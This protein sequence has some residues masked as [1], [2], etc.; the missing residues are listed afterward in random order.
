ML[1]A[2]PA[3]AQPPAF[4]WVP[5][6]PALPPPQGRVIRVATVDEL[7][8]AANTVRPG[9]TILLADGHYDMPRYLELRTDGVSLRSASGDRTKVVLDGAKSG[10]GE[11]LGLRACADVTIA[12]LTVQNVKWNGIKIN[13]ET[14]VQRVTIHNCVI[15]NVWQRGVKGVKVPAENRAAT[16]PAGCRVQHCFFY[17]DRPKQYADDPADTA[18]NF[19][20]NYIGGIDVMYAKDWTICDNVFWGIRGRTGEARAAVFL[21]HES[22]DCTVERNLIV[23]CDMGIALGNSHRPP[24]TPLHATRCTV[25]NNFV[26]RAPETGILADYTRD[27]AIVH[28]TIHDPQSRMRRLIRLVH[29]NDGLQVMNNLLSGPAMSVETESTVAAAGN[30]TGSFASAFVDPAGGNLHL[31]TGDLPALGRGVP[32]LERAPADIDRRQRSERT[33]PGAHQRH[34]AAGPPSNMN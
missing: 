12:D 3:L 33:D 18:E 17:N 8:R 2:A 30:A 4:D 14:N 19:R 21:W 23:D 20:G 1:L 15:R 16:R 7:F 27:C 11:L 5:K 24:D 28:N 32:R 31:K 34:R 10:L 26:T 22:E 13:S 29:D 25:R 9:E 6:A